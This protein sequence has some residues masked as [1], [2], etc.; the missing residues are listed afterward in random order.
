MNSPTRAPVYIFAWQYFGTAIFVPFYCFVEL[1]RHFHSRH[2]SD[3]SV[4]YYQA[5]ALI[6]AAIIA[7]IHPYRMV[8]FPPSSITLSQ[9]QAFIASYQLGPF[10]CYALVAAFANYFTSDGKTRTTQP[11][12]ADVPWIKATYA[13]FG[14][15]SAIVHIAVLACVWR[16]GD[17]S[18]S[19]DTLFVPRWGQLWLP[20]AAEALYVEESLFFLQWDF[21][22]VTLSCMIY[23]ARILEAMRGSKGDQE[24][25]L[26][27]ALVVLGCGIVCVIFSPGAVVSAVLFAREDFLRQQFSE[28]E[29]QK[30][31]KQTKNAGA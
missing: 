10:V 11:A 5:K 31:L 6:P 2:G 22:L 14:A 25:V 12:N 7:V 30:M 26:K 23:V 16:S 17:P 28:R 27:N 15:F 1:N 29:R 21:I 9:H 18:V 24:P 19:F 4:P 13:I 8:Y 20:N 3:P